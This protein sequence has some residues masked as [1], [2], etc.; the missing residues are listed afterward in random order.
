MIGAEIRDDGGHMGSITLPTWFFEVM[1]VFAFWAAH[2]RF[3]LPD[4]RPK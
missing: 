3:S 1:L 2:D 4:M